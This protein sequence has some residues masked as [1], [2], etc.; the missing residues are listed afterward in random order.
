[1]ADPLNNYGTGTDS[2]AQQNNQSLPPGIINQTKQALTQLA[3]MFPL[4][5]PIGSI[6]IS[7]NPTNPGAKTMFNFGTWAAFGEGQVLVGVAPTGTFDTALAT[8]GEETHVLDT[9]EMP[10]HNHTYSTGSGQLIAFSGGGGNQGV[11]SGNTNGGV[12]LT[13]GNTGGD[14]AHNNLQPY[15]VVYMWQRTG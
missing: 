1:M 11:T 9:T 7:T 2:V 4:I 3:T 10:S 6:Y 5:Y 13:I 15:I 8:G 14:G 12:S